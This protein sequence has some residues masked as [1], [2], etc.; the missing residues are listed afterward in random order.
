L[1]VSSYKCDFGE[2]MLETSVSLGYIFQL[3]LM[4]LSEKMFVFE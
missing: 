1:T 3:I 2:T 4:N